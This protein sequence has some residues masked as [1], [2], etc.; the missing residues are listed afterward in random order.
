MSRLAHFTKRHYILEL[1]TF[2]ALVIFEVYIAA[3]WSSIGDTV[4]THF[5]FDGQP[6]AWGDKSSLLFMPILTI[7]LY[8]LLSITELFP[9]I[10]NFPVELTEAN[11]DKMIAISLDMVIVLKLML[12]VIFAFITWLS[13]DFGYLPVW[14]LPVY[15]VA[16]FGWIGYSIYRMI[17]YDHLCKQSTIEK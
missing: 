13:I 17:H 12:V 2:L 5:G 15:M 6:D 8:L 9:K 4:P 16:L 14:F 10:W 7:V 1:V 11:R 3:R